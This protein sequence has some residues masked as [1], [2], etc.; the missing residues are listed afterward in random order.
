MELC[1]GLGD[2][3][4][5]S[6]WVRVKEGTGVGVTVVGVGWR[7]PGQD[8]RVQEAAGRRRGAASRLQVLV[9]KD[10]LNQP[11]TCWRGDAAGHKQLRGFSEGVA[12]LTSRHT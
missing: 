12:G 8:E 11:G 10:C 9:F 5:G 6:L 4:T 1:L 7:L 2:E 3:P